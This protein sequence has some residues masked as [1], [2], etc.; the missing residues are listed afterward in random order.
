MM[1]G[2]YKSSWMEL[3]KKCMAA[4]R[5]GSCCHLSNLY[6]GSIFLPLLQVLLE[7]TSWKHVGWSAVVPEFL[8]H[9]GNYV[10]MASVLF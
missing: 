2:L 4:L 10:F 9:P 3:I 5:I 1:V 6:Y 7:R 8:S